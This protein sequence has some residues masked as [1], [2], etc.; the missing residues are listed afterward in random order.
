MNPRPTLAVILAAGRGIRFGRAGQDQPKGFIVLGRETL[1]SRSIKLLQSHGISE[2]VIVTGHCREHYE[3]LARAHP[4]LI[5][6]V[7]NPIYANSGSLASLQVAR[8]IIDG[9]PYLLLE[10]D[11]IYESAAIEVV[12][13]H[14]DESVLLVS[15]PTGSGDEVYVTAQNG[16]LSALTKISAKLKAP[17]LGELVGITKIGS[18]FAKHLDHVTGQKLSNTN[19]V[20]YEEALVTA[21][22]KAALTCHL[23]S[24]LVWSEID[25][26]LH[27]TRAQSEILPRLLSLDSAS[28]GS[29]QTSGTS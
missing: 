23:I 2:I 16:Q 8:E 25:N 14:P 1:I 15:G 26:D 5:R 10:S 29:I 3:Q 22:R 18:R 12:L 4:S 24:D 13:N 6:L 20:E 27:L 21:A 19:H 11:L 9:R 7:H 17:P 28:A